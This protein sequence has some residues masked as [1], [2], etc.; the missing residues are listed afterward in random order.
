MIRQTLHKGREPWLRDNTVE[1]DLEGPTYRL[2]VYGPVTHLIP[3]NY[4][5][6]CN[7]ISF[8]I[9]FSKKTGKGNQQ[10]LDLVM[11]SS[12]DRRR[13]RKPTSLRSHH[14]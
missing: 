10:V 6:L 3:F 1:A 4:C 2:R 9:C 13:Q 12:S 7:H 5:F 14:V 11:C 8:S